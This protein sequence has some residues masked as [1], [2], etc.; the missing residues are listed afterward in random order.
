MEGLKSNEDGG[1]NRTPHAE[2]WKA[3]KG[4]IK[5][6]YVTRNLPLSEV[7]EEMEK[8]GFIAT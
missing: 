2:E 3:V 1:L 5:D 7:M 6:L 8:H 4:N